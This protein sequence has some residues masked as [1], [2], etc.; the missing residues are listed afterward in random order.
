MQQ[1]D[2]KQGAS[3]FKAGALLATLLISACARTMAGGDGGCQSYAE[4]RIAIPADP[5]PAG[6]WGDWVADADDRMTGACR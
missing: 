3:L 1:K 6:P 4:A 5:V 2:K